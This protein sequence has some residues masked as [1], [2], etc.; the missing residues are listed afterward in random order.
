MLSSKERVFST[1]DHGITYR[2][3]GLYTEIDCHPLGINEKVWS[4]KPPKIDPNDIVAR[5]R[6]IL[7]KYGKDF[8]IVGK[9]SQTTL[10]QFLVDLLTDKKY[11]KYVRRS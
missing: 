3:I 11:G 2:N 6:D 9:V 10:D 1:L 8:A 5:T 4:Y 7:T